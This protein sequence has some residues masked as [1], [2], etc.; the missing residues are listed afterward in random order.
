[1]GCQAISDNISCVAGE[2]QELIFNLI[3]YSGMPYDATGCSV[4][5]AVS[6]YVN[7]GYARPY[8]SKNGTA[9]ANTAHV[10]LL[11]TETLELPSSK[12]FYQLTLKDRDGNV[13]VPAR[14]FFFVKDNI[15]PDFIREVNT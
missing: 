2:T 15:N 3:D 5:F 12:L 11:S 7:L 1:M 4:N 6:D 9:D 13:E 10:V 8:L 14:G